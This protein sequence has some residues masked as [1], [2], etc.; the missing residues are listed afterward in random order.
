MSHGARVIVRASSTTQLKLSSTTANNA[1]LPVLQL[2][3]ARLHAWE[4]GA[5]E[6]TV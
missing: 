5:A 4:P 3:V 1:L 6:A 2:A